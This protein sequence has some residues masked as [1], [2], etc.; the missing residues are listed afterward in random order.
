MSVK[1][2]T[3]Y[4]CPQCDMTKTVLNGEGIEFETVNVED[5]EAA[6]KYIKEDLGYSSMPVTIKE[7]HNPIV[8]FNPER[9]KELKD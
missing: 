9:F 5:D 8:G 1:V 6:L 7:G 3:K 4:G 2:Y